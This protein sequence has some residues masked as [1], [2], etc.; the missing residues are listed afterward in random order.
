MKK[1]ITLLIMIISVSCFSQEKKMIKSGYITFN[2]NSMLEFK[3]LTI[4]NGNATY[5]NEVSQTQMTF[6]LSSVKKIM[7]TNGTIV[8]ETERKP[9]ANTLA[10]EQVAKNDVAIL[11]KKGEE[12][13]VYKSAS[14]IYM[15]GEKVSD[16]KLEAL[17]KV[18]QE[19]YNQYKKGK[20]GA[21]LGSILMG[22]GIG[23]FIGGGLSN[24]SNANSGGGGSP[25]LLII[26]LATT[27]VGIPVRLGG[28]KNSKNAIS[29]YN[30]LPNKQVSCFDK[31]EM[32]VFAS[33]GG[34]GFIL[35]F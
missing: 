33:N 16:D 15:N 19:L 29:S 28:V 31:L 14:K 21:S 7:D 12:K 10:V 1:I 24:L 11:Y 8:Y 9:A 17:L 4:E 5:F 20:S 27:A 35:Q 23:L 30:L 2:S 26:G 32:K 18:N 25:A 34:L 22:G 6:A 13:L 3:N